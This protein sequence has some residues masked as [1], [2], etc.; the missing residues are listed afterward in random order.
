MMRMI[1]AKNI[2]VG[3]V[4]SQGTVLTIDA[5]L[6]AN[7]NMLS[8]EFDTYDGISL[9]MDAQVPVYGKRKAY[10]TEYTEEY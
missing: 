10:T 7:E 8:I 6:L 4:L 2:K 5:E 9:D 1:K 3:H